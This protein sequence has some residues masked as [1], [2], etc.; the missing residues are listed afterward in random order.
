[1][2][3]VVAEVEED[4]VNVKIAFIINIPVFAVI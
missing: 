2:F 3:R 1:M 4:E